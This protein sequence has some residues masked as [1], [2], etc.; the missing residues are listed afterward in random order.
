MI[1]INEFNSFNF[2]KDPVELRKTYLEKVKIYHPDKYVSEK[3]QRIA[4]EKF[5]KLNEAYH[6][7]LNSLTTNSD[8]INKYSSESLKELAKKLDNYGNYESAH[9]QLKRCNE[10]DE[11]W[12]YLN[13]NV[14]MHMKKYSE[15]HDSFRK[16][17]SL[18]PNNKTYRQGA[19]DAAI[20]YKNNSS[21]KSKISSWIDKNITKG[22]I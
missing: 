10:K 21:L 7:A 18:S 4:N 5:V 16:A 2:I 20:A 11:E 6:I 8:I 19:F 12:Y 1:D 15:A 17:V 13:G 22:G 3:E 9:L 14:L